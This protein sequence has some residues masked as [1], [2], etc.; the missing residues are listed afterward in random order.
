M[1]SKGFASTY[2][3]GLL[4][5]GLA[6]GFG[7]LGSRLVWLHVYHRQALLDD[8]AKM[9]QQTLVDPAK[10]GDILDAR[11][12][13]LATS[14]AVMKVGVDPASLRPQ[15]E[16]KWPQLAAMLG[17][18]E[19]DLR[20]IFN[21]K[22]RPIQPATP[23]E[24]ASTAPASASLVLNFNLNR[25]EGAAPVAASAPAPAPGASPIVFGG[26]TPRA[27]SFDADVDDTEFDDKSEN[28]NLKRI[29]WAT[30]KDNVSES[31]YLQIEKLGIKGVYGERV[32]RRTYPNHQL[33][34]HIV[35]FVNKQHEPIA[36]VEAFADFYLRGQNGWRV[37]ERDGRGRE[38]AQFRRREVPKADGYSVKLSID[39]AVQDI[40][41]QELNAI[42]QKYQ[43]LK[44][45]IIVSDPRNGFILG[46]ANYPT[47]DPN[48]YNEVPA[49]EQFRM[50]N[51]AV[52]DIYEPGS[53][54]KIVAAA[55][56]LEENLVRLTDEFDCSLASIAYKGRNLGL[57]AEDHHMGM[58][59]LPEIISRSSNKGAA[60]LGMRLGEERFYRYATAFGFGRRL[61]FPVG[62]EVRG[63]L[64]PPEKWN[65]IDI[66]RIPMGHTIAATAL[67]MHTAMSVI[68]N[69]GVLMRP[70]IVREIRHANGD[71]VASFLGTDSGRVVSEKTA[72]QVAAMLTGVAM[73][74][75]TAPEAAIPGYEV[76][77]KTGTT[78]K[79]VEETLASGK[80]KLVYSSKHHVASFVG[81]FPA[82]RPEVAI[83]V[84][85]DDAD[86]HAPNGVAYGAKVAAP[87][88]KNIGE[89]LIPILKIK[90]PGQ[91]APRVFAVNEGGRR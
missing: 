40:V 16:L 74:G 59:S 87:A 75:G 11:G 29:R 64:L 83:S 31:D 6:L 84:I 12:A 43:P 14:V 63:I 24:A 28:K 34:S 32:Y 46:I 81:F 3:I 72:K 38:L 70:Q 52:A 58:L 66:T 67:Q 5:G 42:A 71:V 13:K 89:K 1:S 44:A 35:G 45:T 23:A 73:K 10:R 26:I 17:L 48:A 55:G 57:P 86:A 79:L 82:S 50:R 21:T 8:I 88:F 51:V 53:V 37:G 77:G 62:G 90:M 49:D 36:G 47:F 85:V 54:F 65:P 4:A 18:P 41:E 22:Y 80:T 7:A 20:R 25:A 91:P 78:Q 69:D 56:A 33:A 60:Q 9:R 27:S 39:S 30:L 76:A 61:G 68:A 15:D 2:R 19:T